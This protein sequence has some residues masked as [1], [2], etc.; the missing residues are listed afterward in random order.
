MDNVDVA[1]LQGMTIS[2]L[3]MMARELGVTSYSGLRKQDLIL[4][5]IDARTEDGGLIFGDGVLE[6]LPEGFG[7]LRSSRYNYLQSPDDIYVSPSQIRRFDLRTGHVVQGQI[8]PPKKGRDGEKEEHYFAL[9]KIQSVNNLEPERAKETML[10]DNLTP[11]HPIEKFTLEHHPKEFATRMMDLMVPVG[12]GQRGLIVAPPFSGKTH[13]LRHIAHGIEANH[14]EVELIVLLIDERPE[15]VTEMQRSVKAE[16]VA[17]TFDETPERHVQ[18]AKIVLEK[19]KR[20]V[21]FGKDVVILLDS[22]TRL[23]RANNV[24]IPHSGRTLT[25][26]MDPMAMQFP[27][28]FFGAARKIEESGS[29]TIISTVLVDTDSKADEYCFEELKGT[30]N[31]EIHLSRPLL[32]RRIFP[33]VDVTQSKTRKEEL[34]LDETELARSWILRKLTS[35]MNA[36]EAMGLFVERMGRTR[37]NKEFLESMK[38]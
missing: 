16:V 17:S 33:P 11:I 6:I 34:L 38:S 5:I 20:M 15:E 19:A 30:G 21:E 23:A 26:G 29:L 10:V 3:T 22:M 25:G 7:F 12:R 18:V 13:L 2:E 36:G 9:L 28:E 14:P 32:D 31:M 1:K 35:Q 8:R 24:I 4:K 37:T 27:R